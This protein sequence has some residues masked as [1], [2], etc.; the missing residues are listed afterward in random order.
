MKIQ[1]DILNSFNLSGEIYALNG[2]Q[3]SSIRVNDAVL[4]PVGENTQFC[5]WGLTIL[6]SINP[7]G[8]RLSKPM[9][10]N[11]GNFVYKGWCCTCYEP[12]EHRQG[13]VNQ[14][15]E[16][17]RLFHK[18]LA[19]IDFTEIPKAND[20]WSIANGIAWQ[21]ENLPSTISKEAVRILEELVGM[22]KLNENYKVQIIHSDLSGNILFDNTRSPLIIDFSPKIAPIEYAEA[23]LVCDCIA[24][25][26]SP[27]SELGLI[28]NSMFHI[29]MIIRAVIF[30]L[31]TAAIFAG[32]DKD[33]FI[34]EY[35]KFKPIL[36][37]IKLWM[38][39]T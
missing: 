14:K 35:K 15:L 27:I 19:K 4:K 23:I 32:D 38:E 18:D 36:D 3:N 17:A 13:E 21:K 24:W 2:G 10:C 31:S 33:E 8:Y 5:E 28:R 16:V 7:H 6:H 22:V 20:P 34:K 12:G 39:E 11:N 1:S 25:Q 30:R 29:E 9:K 26:G 37:I